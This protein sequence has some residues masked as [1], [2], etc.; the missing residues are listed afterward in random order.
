MI[1]DTALCSALGLRA[2]ATIALRAFEWPVKLKLKFSIPES[3]CV[4]TILGAPQLSGPENDPLTAPPRHEIWGLIQF[5]IPGATV[6]LSP[7]CQHDDHH[8]YFPRTSMILI[9]RL[10]LLPAFVLACLIYYFFINSPAAGPV[11]LSGLNPNRKIHWTKKPE[12][13]PVAG[14]RDFPIGPLKPIPKVQFDFAS[15]PESATAAKTRE[16]RRAAVKEAFQHSWNGYKKH[17]WQ[18]SSQISA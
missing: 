6:R 18:V 2:L 11:P 16:T 5:I 15:H 3:L 10:W 7:V 8:T 9:R 4:L 17:A 12:R 13:W 14:Y 1:G